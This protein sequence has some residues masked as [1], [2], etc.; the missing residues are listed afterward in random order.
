[1][2]LQA[3]VVELSPP[4]AYFAVRHIATTISAL[5]HKN[6]KNDS[7]FTYRNPYGLSCRQLGSK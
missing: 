1:M 3:N 6:Y 7:I 4:T 5:L 2:P